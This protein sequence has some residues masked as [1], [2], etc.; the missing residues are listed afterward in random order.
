M[1]PIETKV[2]TEILWRAGILFALIDTVFVAL[3]LRRIDREK[4]SRLRNPLLVTSGVFWFVVWITMCAFFWDPVYHYVFPAWARWIIPPVYGILF[5]LVAFVIWWLALRLPGPPA[6]T[7]C[8]FG[9]L[10]GMVTHLWGI[11]RGLLEKPPM[12][13]GVSVLSASVMP[14]FEFIFY[15][16]IVLTAA[17]ILHMKLGKRH[18][19]EKRSL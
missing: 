3:L 11:S 1:L 6:L 5:V 19:G 14:V 9:G 10:W 17:H 8:F 12:L 15:W 16:C 13:R 7:F 2:T 4:M 18:P